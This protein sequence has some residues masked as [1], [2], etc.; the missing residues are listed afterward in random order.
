MLVIAAGA[1][2]GSVA[3]AVTLDRDLLPD[4]DQGAFTVRMELDESTRLEA[5]ADAATRLEAELLQDEG[6]AAVFSHIGRDVQAMREEGAT[7]DCNTATLQV[8][9]RTEPGRGRR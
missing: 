5:T 4:V 1:L 6:V 7:A 2:G 8:A 3:L 9:W